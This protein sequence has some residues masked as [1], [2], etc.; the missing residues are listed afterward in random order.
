MKKHLF[1]AIVAILVSMSF[2]SCTKESLFSGD[3]KFNAKAPQGAAW[4]GKEV[5]AI[6][7]NGA[8]PVTVNAAE[9]N[10]TDVTAALSQ[11]PASATIYAA[12]PYVEDGDGINALTGSTL[13]LQIPE[14][15][16]SRAGACD[17]S[18]QLLFAQA[19]YSGGLPGSLELPF[20]SILAT[21][22]IVI[23]NAPEAMKSVKLKFSKNVVGKYTYSISDKSFSEK[24]AS[25]EITLKAGADNDLYFACAPV[26]TD[27]AVELTG[28]ASGAVYTV[29]LNTNL[30]AGS[31]TDLNVD[32]KGALKLY[33]V[34]SAVGKEDAA[35]AIAM[36][37]NGDGSFS[38]SGKMAAES[39]FKIIFDQKNLTPAFGLGE[40]YNK[41]KYST[42]ATAAPFEI[43][44][45]GKYT[46]TV[47]PANAHIQ[48]KRTFDHVLA[49][50][51]GA[52]PMDE[53]FENCE[54][55]PNSPHEWET[56]YG[57]VW[58]NHGYDTFGLNEEF[59]LSGKT[60]YWVNVTWVPEDR[61][62][63]RIIRSGDWKQPIAVADKNYTVEMQMMYEG[64]A[65][66]EEIVWRIEGA[67]GTGAGYEESVVLENG[68]PVK[69]SKDFVSDGTWGGCVNFFVYFNK[70]N[71]VEDA[72]FTFFF[73]GL[74]IG[75]DD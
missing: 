6:S 3:V 67:L 23:A 61:N 20:S 7:V 73:D 4:T 55:V 64:D 68:V 75:Y 32:L 15:Q 28:E 60:S 41:I 24:S 18:A 58:Q 11:C 66:S 42:K 52:A 1:F 63:G 69:I 50:S 70:C 35:S 25:S 45:A 54:V 48:V 31:V 37:E 5:I 40:A 44:K 71:L 13:E 33:L 49:A 14:S 9:G 38:W 10:S 74:N 65:E 27:V 51:D 53:E 36:T 12:V 21:G 22:R 47:W 29:A 43:E 8:A 17:A 59:K 34:G 26:N 39:E 46:V 62:Q 57:A 30:V 72:P 19:S 16:K 56:R 2:V